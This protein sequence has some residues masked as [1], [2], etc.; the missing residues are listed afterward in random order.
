M[1]R[2]AVCA[3]AI[4]L[5][6]LIVC[7]MLFI[8][9]RLFPGKEEVNSSDIQTEGTGGSAFQGE[10]FGQEPSEEDPPEQEKKYIV[11]LDAGHGGKDNGTS[12]DRAKEK[13]I[14]LAI[15]L[16][17]EKL[18]Q[19]RGIETLLTRGDDSFLKLSER[20]VIANDQGASLFISIHCNAYDKDNRVKGLECYYHPD[21]SSGKELAEGICKKLKEDGKIETR[22][23]RAEDYA[24][25]R[26][27]ECKSI[28]IEIGYLT[29]A[30]EREKLLDEEYQN[31]LAE[32]LVEALCS[33]NTEMNPETDP[34]G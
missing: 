13:D 14:N 11:I 4:L 23:A 20:A 2:G 5:L 26:E 6:L 12:S 25:L 15:V 31:M 27:T 8:K 1:C 9:E 28:L 34:A 18:L 29:N 3:A 10:N 22:S 21:S 24:V 19:E 7:G 30:S 16:K 33:I 17:M 32:E